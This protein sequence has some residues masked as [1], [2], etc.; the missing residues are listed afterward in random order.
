MARKCA[1]WAIIVGLVLLVAPG[2]ASAKALKA[3]VTVSNPDGTTGT[4][5]VILNYSQGAA[6]LIANVNGSGLQPDC[7]YTVNVGVLVDVIDPVTGLV[8]GQTLEVYGSGKMDTRAAKV[9]SGLKGNGDPKKP[10]NCKAHVNI[11]IP[12]KQPAPPVLLDLT[13]EV[14]GVANP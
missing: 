5:K 14:T 13:V 10:A 8:T 1:M 7:T 2:L 6:G 4:A 3:E 9:K 12:W 11:H